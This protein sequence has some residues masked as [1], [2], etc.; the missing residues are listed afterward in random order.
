MRKDAHRNGGLAFN[1]A[2]ASVVV[3]VHALTIA[4]A[5]AVVWRFSAFYLKEVMIE[6]VGNAA[7]G[8][9]WRP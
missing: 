8:H 1:G 2:V 3:H 5:A 6:L 9:F 4:R 7:R